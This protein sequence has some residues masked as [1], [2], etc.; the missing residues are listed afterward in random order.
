MDERLTYLLIDAC[1]IAVPL[2][3]SFHPAIRFYRQWR[4]FVPAMAITALVFLLWDALFTS[5][6][7]WGFNPRYLVGSYFAGLPIEEILFFVCIPYAC[8]F[9]FHCFKVFG[10]RPRVG[11]TK[12]VTYLLATVFIGISASHFSLYYTSATFLSL[13]V[14]LVLAQ[15]LIADEMPAFYLSFLLALIPFF[16]SN[17]LLTGSWIAEPVVVYNDAFNLKVRLGTIPVEDIFYGME[18]QLMNVVGFV[19]LRKRSSAV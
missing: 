2:G 15:S 11:G 12:I 8:L 9:I 3:A 7:V 4:F 18:F 14:M 19:L 10:I 13:G 5:I 1:C 17:G 16:I 6:G